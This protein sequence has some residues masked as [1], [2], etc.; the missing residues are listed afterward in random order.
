MTD[1]K[2]LIYISDDCTS[3]QELL[4]KMDQWAVEY[5]V[6][7]ITDNNQNKKELQEYGIYGTPATFIEKKKEPILGYQ[8]D[9]LKRALNVKGYA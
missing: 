4:K 7:N 9:K 6:K 8:I 3:C 2:A 1:T 5:K